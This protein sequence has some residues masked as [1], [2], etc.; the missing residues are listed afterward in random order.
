MI[1]SEFNKMIFFEKLNCVRILLIIISCFNCIFLMG[2]SQPIGHQLTEYAPVSPNAASLGNYGLYPV[3]HNLGTIGVNVPIYTISTGKQ[4]LPIS[5]SY[6]TSGVKV[7][8]L[9]S[10]VGLGWTLNAGGAIIRNVKGRPG[11]LAPYSTTPPSPEIYDL[12]NPTFN[13]TNFNYMGAVVR[14]VYDGQPDEFIINAPGISTS[15]Y[16]DPTNDEAVFKDQTRARVEIISNNEIVVT[17]MDG[18]RLR[19]GRD[20]SGL[21]N[22]TEVSTHPATSYENAFDYVSTWFL[23]EMISVTSSDIIKFYYKEKSSWDYPVATGESIVIDGPTPSQPLEGNY[24]NGTNVSKRYLERIEFANGYVLFNSVLDRQDLAD[25]YRLEDIEVYSGTYGS[26]TLLTRY[27]FNYSYFT[28]SGGVYPTG[29]NTI[30]GP[31]AVSFNGTRMVNSRTKSLK[32]NDITIGINGLGGAYAFEYNS[33][34]L[35]LRGS[36][37]LDSWGYANTNTGSLMPKTVGMFVNSV[38][39]FAQTIEYDQGNGDREAD[40][41]KMKAAVLNKIIYPTGGYTIFEYEPNQY[42]D[43]FT[44]RDQI[45]KSQTVIAYGP[46]D[47]TPS[48]CPDQNFQE[49]TFTVASGDYVPASGQLSISFSQAQGIDPTRVVFD[50]TQYNPPSPDANEIYASSFQT[51]DFNMV[52]QHT[53]QAYEYRDAYQANGVYDCAITSATASWNEY[54]PPYQI[55]KTVLLGG[56]R[57]KEVKN[58]DGSSANPV[59]TKQFEYSNHNILQPEN[60]KAFKK[61]F[62]VDKA[63]RLELSTNLFYDNNLSGGPSVEYG[64]VTEF[65]INSINQEPLGKTVYEYETI[66]RQRLIQPTSG[67]AF[68]KHPQATYDAD[69]NINFGSVQ[70]DNIIDYYRN[71]T[72]RLGFLDKKEV[73]K[74]KGT[75]GSPYVQIYEENHSYIELSKQDISHNYVFLNTNNP[76][77]FIW[78]SSPVAPY[79]GSSHALSYYVADVEV[80]RKV[81]EQKT[82]SEYDQDGLNPRVTTT[83]YHYDNSDHL[84]PTRTIVTTSDGGPMITKT[85]YP[86]DVTTGSLQGGDLTIDANLAVAQLK[87]NGSAYR[88]AA[89]IQMETYKDQ[90]DDGLAESNELLTVQ[91]TNYKD[92]DI[93]LGLPTNTD[94][95]LPSGSMFLSGV[96]DPSTNPLELR[97][98]YHEYSS[99]GNPLEL[100]RKDDYHVVYIWGYN[101][102]FPIAKIVNASYADIPSSTIADIQSK[103][104]L[105]N[106]HCMGTSGCNEATLRVA[107][108]DLRGISG[109][110][111]AMI[112]TYTYD[113]QVGMTSQTDLNGQTTYYSYD[114]LGRLIEVVDFEGNPLTK[115]EY[116]YRQ[117]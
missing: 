98:I 69:L 61:F 55:Q 21:E 41:V 37:S 63:L 11:P 36:T 94:I 39:G 24:P 87:S 31:A 57:I 111:D 10:W 54:G 93:D 78:D 99:D 51:F 103:S 105:D 73:Y 30:Q 108:N 67:I 19:F 56:L 25:E 90:D 91:R 100:S 8:D 20:A 3:N 15:F 88:I 33:T 89:P 70:N 40:E 2:Q 28:R 117:E 34:T 112:T 96:Y 14:G 4:E 32:L 110:S 9:A 86:D 44:Q 12:S 52:G 13:E 80:G 22:A 68:F 72:W 79:Y 75:T 104:N 5:L 18:T 64:T 43:N 23:T 107:L 71:D 81:L 16:Y 92:W 60:N 46:P 50:G 38:G 95:I 62:L 113:P 102:R 59:S 101:E 116:H 97:S 106:D 45:G 48:D 47:N 26:G 7:N 76:N 77:V 29:Y 6:N 82:I 65:D 115:T 83:T 74:G 35:P 114:E 85:H 58:Y 109:L 53:I 66:P 84:L 42:T 27:T 1:N 49:K 17:R